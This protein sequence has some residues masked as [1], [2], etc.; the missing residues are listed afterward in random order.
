MSSA[1][2]TVDQVLGVLA[3][4]IDPELKTDIVE[5]GMVGDISIDP[6]GEVTVPVVLTTAGCP[7]RHQIKVDVQSKVLGLPGVE[8]VRVEYGEMTAE[9]KAAAMSRARFQAREHAEPTEVAAT[10]RVLAIASGKGGVGKS[11]ITVN[12][13]SALAARGLAVGVLDADIWGFSIPRMLG[14][15]D[16]LGGTD[17]KIEP[18][19][20][21]VE[22]LEPGGKPGRLAVVSMGFLV[23]DERSALMWRG[24]VLTRALEQFLTDV[25]WGTL[26]YLLID[27]PPGTGDIQMGLARMLPQAEMLVVTTPALAAQH[28]ASRVADMARR[29]H[30]KVAGVVENMTAFVTPSGERYALFGEGGG[31]AL[32]R[33]ID[34]PLLAS[35]PIEP[36]VASGGDAGVPAVLAAPTGVAAQAFRDLAVAIVED[37]LPPIE[38][39]GCTA[40][41]MELIEQIDAP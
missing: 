30:M 29:S 8:S 35:I 13:A 28:V 17:G 23:D 9:Q 20:V 37:V 16:R 39:A 40:R 19:E 34:A 41:M 31:A 5:L 36:A 2:P 18:I 12:L 25:R 15:D 10:T 27:M 33:D 3:G 21:P 22:P 1:L 7:L 6:S 26:D 32:A 24:L 38:M 14:I 4:V 11:S